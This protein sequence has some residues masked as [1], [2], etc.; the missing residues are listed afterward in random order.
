[1]DISVLVKVV[2]N[3]SILNQLIGIESENQKLMHLSQSWFIEI[4]DANILHQA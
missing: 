3:N 1:V 4:G 2:N